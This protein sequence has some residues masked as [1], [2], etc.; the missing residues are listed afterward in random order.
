MRKWRVYS[1][2]EIGNSHRQRQE[3]RRRGIKQAA[4]Q[5]SEIGHRAN[6]TEF[7]YDLEQRHFGGGIIVNA[8]SVVCERTGAVAEQGAPRIVP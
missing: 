6:E 2:Q 7:E 4:K 3:S 8:R 5:K 1:V